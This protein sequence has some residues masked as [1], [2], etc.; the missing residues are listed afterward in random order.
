MRRLTALMGMGLLAACGQSGSN[1]SNDVENSFNVLEGETAQGANTM[2]AAENAI[3]NQGEPDNVVVGGLPLRLGYYVAGDTECE[4]ASNSTITLMRR[5]G[6]G[7]ARYHCTFG[8][9]EKIGPTTFRVNERCTEQANFGGDRE[10]QSVTRTYEVP[11]DASFS[12]TSDS[13]WGSKARFCAQS[14][15]PEPW[16]DNDISDIGGR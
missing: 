8:T 16:R 4:K 6:Y 11:D 5:D 3:E 15:L 14:S 12:A 2:N 7:G 13:G 1:L 10:A 9:I